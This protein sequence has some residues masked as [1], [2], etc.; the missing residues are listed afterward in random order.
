MLL[1]L[2]ELEVQEGDF[3]KNPCKD[4]D[5]K[6]YGAYYD[7]CQRYLDHK[8]LLKFHKKERNEE[9]EF[10]HYKF[11]QIYKTKRRCNGRNA[12]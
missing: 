12:T 1:A 8:E 10:N 2:V 5:R 9:C 6:G 4:C 11:N 3:L 7:I